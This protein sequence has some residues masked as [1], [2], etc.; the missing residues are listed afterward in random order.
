MSPKESSQEILEAR[1]QLKAATNAM[2]SNAAAM[3][4]LDEAMAGKN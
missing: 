1:E 4:Y 3:M 2:L